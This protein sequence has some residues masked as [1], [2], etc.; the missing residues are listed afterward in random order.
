[1]K[2]PI[3][4]WTVVL[5]AMTAL[6][7]GASASTSRAH[8]GYK[9]WNP[10]VVQVSDARLK[11]EVNATAEDGGVQVFLD[12]DP[13]KWM[14]IFDPNG[15]RIF[16]S[17]TSGSIGKQGGTELFLE[18]GEPEFSKQSLEELLE[19]FPEGKYRFRGRGLEGERLVG[20]AILTHNIPN[21]P[22]LVSPLEGEGP[23]DPNDTVVV[24][25]PVEAPNGRPIIAYQV[26]VVRADTGFP[27]L[28]K[29]SLDVMMP[30]TAT[31]M[32]VPPGFLLPDTEYEWEV[33]AIEAS[34]N[35]TLSSSFFRTAP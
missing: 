32:I 5:V 26:L 34:G 2:K 4:Y 11:F 35:Q 23:V 21:G 15:R 1:M 18:S 9:K 19:L 20:T 10:K 31:S 24:W 30:A 28:P 14:A 6:A 16:F 13:W 33:L 25:E 7:I 3:H 8:G 29:V 27:A 12:A 17:T 22:E